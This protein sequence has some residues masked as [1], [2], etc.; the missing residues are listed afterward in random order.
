MPFLVIFLVYVHQMLLKNTALCGKRFWFHSITNISVIYIQF[1]RHLLQV[2]VNMSA[3]EKGYPG[4]KKHWH[5][6]LM[7]LMIL[8]SYQFVVCA[9]SGK[10]RL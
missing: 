9:P 3:F 2:L 5:V 7:S 1:R 4:L 10:N 6:N 8:A